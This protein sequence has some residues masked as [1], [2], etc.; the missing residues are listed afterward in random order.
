MSHVH[1]YEWVMS[2]RMNESCP[3]VWMSHV[4]TYEWV[5][6]TCINDFCPHVWMSRFNMQIPLGQMTSFYLPVDPRNLRFL[7]LVRVSCL[8]GVPQCCSMLQRV[9]VRCS[10]LQCVAVRCSALQCVAVCC[11]V[12]QC[13]AVCCAVLQYVAVYCSVRFLRL[14]R[15]NVYVC[16]ELFLQMAWFVTC[17]TKLI[18]WFVPFCSWEC[19]WGGYD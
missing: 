15:V 18:L 19:V 12:L 4:H 1:T 9:A 13:A 7:R 2:T 8:R 14:V 3:H 17:V 11:S 5:M 10:V 6:S 16:H